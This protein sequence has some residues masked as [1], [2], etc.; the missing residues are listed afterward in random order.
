M[1]I[2]CMPK[3]VRFSTNPAANPSAL[4]KSTSRSFGN[5][6]TLGK[7]YTLT[8]LFFSLTEDSNFTST[9]LRSTSSTVSRLRMR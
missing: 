5:S 6:T 2:H 7:F 1:K 8:A 9:S 3:V 4:T